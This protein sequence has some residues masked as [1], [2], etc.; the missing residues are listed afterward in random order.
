MVLESACVPVP[1]E[2][3]MLFGGA[4]VTAPFLAEHQQLDLWGV[5]A[6]GTAGNVVGSWLAYW[7]GSAGGRPLVERWGRYLL[8]R[9][10]EIDRAHDWFERYG[11]AAVFVGRLLPV[12]R[13]F[14]SLPAG[15]VRMRFWRFTL[16]TVLGCLP[17]SLLLAG[18]GYLLGERWETVE[19]VFRPIAWAIAAALVVAGVWFV[20]RRVRQIR[21]EEAARRTLEEAAASADVEP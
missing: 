9:P 17:W 13:T 16:Y 8:I 21:A 3:T 5:V 11:Q 19:A 18:L 4:L 20:R 7:A 2:V 12:V 15:V 10:H 6:A 14:I 1:S